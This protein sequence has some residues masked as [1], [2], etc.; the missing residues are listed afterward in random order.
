MEG[1]IN[2]GISARQSPQRTKAGNYTDEVFCVERYIRTMICE[3]LEDKDL[4]NTVSPNC[5][6]MSDA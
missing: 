4:F 6:L 3:C 1:E 5:C 2:K